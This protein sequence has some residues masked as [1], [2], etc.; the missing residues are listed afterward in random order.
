MNPWPAANTPG[1]GIRRL[2]ATQEVLM[3]LQVPC[4][5]DDIFVSSNAA[6][7]FQRSKCETYVSTHVVPR[8]GDMGLRPAANNPGFRIH[9]LLRHRMI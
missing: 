9:R 4:A 7:K 1:F 6:V 3:I 2:L 5:A 8:A